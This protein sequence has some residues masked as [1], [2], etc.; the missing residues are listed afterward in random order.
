MSAKPLTAESAQQ[1][2]PAVV[3]ALAGHTSSWHRTV[4]LGNAYS[5][6][7]LAPAPQASVPTLCVQSHE[8]EHVSVVWSWVHLWSKWVV[9]AQA[10]TALVAHAV[11]LEKR[12]GVR[13]AALVVS[14]GYDTLE[15][16][17]EAGKRGGNLAL[18]PA[19]FCAMG[20]R[21]VAACP[22]VLI[23]QEGGY[24]LINVPHAARELVAGLERG[25]AARG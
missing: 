17:P 22:R 11:S 6:P 1:R 12:A 25:L 4:P 21:L 13:S 19:D 10:P 16:D 15:T 24:D 18:Q 9:A 5:V 2:T 7:M 23:V 3:A 8:H 14:L 20:E